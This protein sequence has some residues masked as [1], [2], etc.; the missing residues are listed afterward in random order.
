M[1]AIDSMIIHFKMLQQ[2]IFAFSV[3]FPKV[4]VR[5]SWSRYSVKNGSGRWLLLKSLHCTGEMEFLL[6]ICSMVIGWRRIGLSISL[7]FMLT[8]KIHDLDNFLNN[9]VHGWKIHCK[10]FTSLVW[11]RNMWF[12]LVEICCQTYYLVTPGYTIKFQTELLCLFCWNCSPKP[13]P[14]IEA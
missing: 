13:R 10:C 9:T 11:A 8:I 14:V 12:G 7:V 1:F 5:Q 3:Q 6:L 4:L 2:V